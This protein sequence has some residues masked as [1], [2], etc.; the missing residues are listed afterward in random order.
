MPKGGKGHEWWGC[1]KCK[2][3]KIY[4]AKIRIKIIY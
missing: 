4:F 2:Y 3:A 1:G